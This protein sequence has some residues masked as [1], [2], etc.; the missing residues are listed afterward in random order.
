MAETIQ[1]QNEGEKGQKERSISTFRVKMMN[2]MIK[3]PRF[4]ET[5]LI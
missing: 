3:N 2:T 4:P 1:R 5:A